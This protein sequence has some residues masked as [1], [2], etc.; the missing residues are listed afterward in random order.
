MKK[1]KLTN[2]ENNNLSEKEMN[3]L[4]GGT[5][6]GCACAYEGTP[7]GSNTSDNYNAN[8]AEGKHSPGMI[9][10]TGHYDGE[11]NWT[12]CDEWLAVV[13]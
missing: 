13:D 1:L 4:R 5:S 6:C 3:N 10:I 12:L 7:G 8:N 11:G 9:H 2:L